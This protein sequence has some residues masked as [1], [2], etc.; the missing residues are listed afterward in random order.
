MM[1]NDDAVSPVIGVILMVAITVIL[2]AVIAV[3][4]FNMADDVQTPRTVMVSAK[5]VPAGI[6]STIWGG[7]GLSELISLNYSV[8]GNEVA[9]TTVNFQVGNRTIISGGAAGSQFMVVGHF[10][11][12]S[13]QILLDKQF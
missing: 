6:E 5:L 11:D 7:T 3:F 12:G 10:N 4:A 2:A 8:A 1:R 9:N 13:E